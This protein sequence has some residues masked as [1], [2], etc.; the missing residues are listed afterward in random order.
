MTKG[1]S[2]SDYLESDWPPPLSFFSTRRRRYTLGAAIA[3]PLVLIGMLSNVHPGRPPDHAIA[4]CTSLS[5][6][7]QAGAPDFRRLRAKFAASRWPDLRADGTAYADL[8]LTLRTARHTDGHEAVWSYQRLAAVCA[9][10]F[11]GN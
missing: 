4:A 7:H 3:T 6:V 5:G 1:G 10:H 9:K 8:A 2:M 11:A